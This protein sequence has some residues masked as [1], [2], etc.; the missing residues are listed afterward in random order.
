MST[1]N[2]FNKIENEDPYSMAYVDNLLNVNKT[3]EL[4]Y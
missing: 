4:L 2:K 3:V 1:I